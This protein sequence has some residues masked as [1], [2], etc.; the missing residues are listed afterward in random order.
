MSSTLNKQR[1]NILNK[2]STL[3][4]RIEQALKKSGLKPHELAKLAGVSRAT[5]SLWVNGPTKTIEG[6]NLTRAARALGV[7]PHWLATGEESRLEP[8]DYCDNMLMEPGEVYLLPQNNTIELVKMFN[9][10]NSIDK[11][12]AIE[13]IKVLRD[14]P[15]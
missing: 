4:E 8:V 6:E 14:I 7:D 2:M 3:Q 15:S 11:K 9:E 12:R 1:F 13:I 10:L 5:V